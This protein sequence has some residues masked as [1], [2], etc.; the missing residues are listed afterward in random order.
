M[1]FLIIIF[2]LLTFSSS[3]MELINPWKGGSQGVELNQILVQYLEKHNIQVKLVNVDHCRLVPTVWKQYKSPITISWSDSK[4]CVPSEVS[5]VSLF[6]QAG[7]VFC[8]L[9]DLDFNKKSLKI[10]W[11]ASAPLTG[12]YEAFEKKYGQLQKIPYSNSGQQIQGVI[13]G[14][15]D[16]ALLGQ[17]SALTSSLNC[18]LSTMP[19]KNINIFEFTE[20]EQYLSLLAVLYENDSIK[21]IMESFYR[22]PEI[23]AWRE[24]RFLTNPTTTNQRNYFLSN[25]FDR[26]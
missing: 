21:I 24:K 4:E 26:K 18:F 11:Q 7:Q 25:V 14:E 22:T 20:K 19:L 16:I 5:N 1:K 2:S 3:A 6:S 10:G 8:S 17:G 13:A 9:K 12:L 15:I 23:V